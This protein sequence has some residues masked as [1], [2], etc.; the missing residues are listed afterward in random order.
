MKAK[1]SKKLIIVLKIIALIVALPPAALLSLSLISGGFDTE[2]VWLYL[3]LATAVVLCGSFFLVGHSAEG[4][5]ITLFALA[6]SIV[7]GGIGF[8]A[9]YCR[10]DIFG[11][12]GNLAPA[13]GIFW[14]GPI[15]FVGG[16]LAG[17]ALGCVW[18]FRHRRTLSR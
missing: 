14:T 13:M 3:G 12:H 7:L 2:L 4:R 8:A 1:P 11:W 9:G 17:W 16:A 15:G 18:V 5:T 6:G 10:P